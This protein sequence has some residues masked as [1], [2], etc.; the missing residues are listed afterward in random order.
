MPSKPKVSVTLSQHYNYDYTAPEYCKPEDGRDYG[1]EQYT[2]EH[3]F[4]VERTVNTL[5]PAIGK[6]LLPSQV[7]A[8]IDQG[9]QVTIQPVR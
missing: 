4:Q 7:Q 5:S 2:A 1:N 6:S 8:L 3:L 9:I